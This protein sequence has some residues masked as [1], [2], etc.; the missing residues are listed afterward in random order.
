MELTP[1]TR[2]EPELVVIGASWGGLDAVG[3]LL[4]RLT[5]PLSCPMALV[6]HRS[7]RQ[8]DLAALLARRTSLPVREADDKEAIAPGHIYVA[9]PGYHLLVQ[10]GGFALSTEAPVR[11]SRPSIDVLFDSAADAY[12]PRLIGV[13]L[14]GANDDGARGLARIQARGGTTLVQDPTTAARD[15][16]PR[17]ALEHLSP[18][19]VAPLDELA[20]ALSDLCRRRDGQAATIGEDMS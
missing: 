18:D 11:H 8:S 12:G 2:Q 5:P 20:V 19:L 17:A 13:L 16:M 14:T 3:H 15:H 7:P 9:P 1:A 6:L 4:A 10:S